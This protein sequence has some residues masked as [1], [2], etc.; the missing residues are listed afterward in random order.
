MAFVTG[1]ALR[2]WQVDTQILLEDEWHA[3]HK[4]LRSS[5]LD[6]FTHLG[7]ADYSIPLT[8]YYQWLE[9]NV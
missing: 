4:L 7:H 6:I 8:L 1:L 9:R 3:I 2:V 5:A